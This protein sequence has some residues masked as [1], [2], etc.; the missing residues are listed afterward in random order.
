ME[1]ALTLAWQVKPTSTVHVKLVTIFVL[2]AYNL[3]TIALNAITDIILILK[4]QNVFH[5][6]LVLTG[7]N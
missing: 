7:N 2:N 1:N 3:F 6:H 5:N 4:H